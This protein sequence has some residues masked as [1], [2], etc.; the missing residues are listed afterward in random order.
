VRR[1][2][3]CDACCKEFVTLE[4]VHFSKV[5]VLGKSGEKLPFDSDRL[6]LAMRKSD[7]S[8]SISDAL[9]YRMVDSMAKFFAASKKPISKDEIIE[10]AAI[11]LAEKDSVAA[12]RFICTHQK[13]ASVAS[14]IDA[15]LKIPVK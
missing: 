11:L 9:L 6:L 15:M 14:M 13:F 7:K 3:L 12:A 5:Y 2:R 4:K 1:R 10:K 8:G